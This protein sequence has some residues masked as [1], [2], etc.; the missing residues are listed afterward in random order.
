MELTK[1]LKIMLESTLVNGLRNLIWTNIS[2]ANIE[3][4]LLSITGQGNV[5]DLR[6]YVNSQSKAT[7][8]KLIEKSP[9][10]T[11]EMVEKAYEKYHY[12]QKPGFT[13]FWAKSANTGPIDLDLFG[14]ELKLYLE[15]IKYESDAK[16][17][18]LKFSNITKF[19]NV[20]EI[21]MT[22]LQRLIYI[23]EEG[24]FKSVYT[25][26]E[27]FAWI[28]I[29]KGFIAINNIPDKLLSTLKDYFSRKLNACIT[30]IKI[31][32]PVLQ[33]AFSDQNRKRITGY[34]PNPS[35]NQLEKIT[36]SDPKLN[37]KMGSLPVGYENY[38][39]VSTQ[40]MEEIDSNTSGLLGVNCDK[41]KLYISKNLTATQ[42]HEWSI[43][44]IN[45]ILNYFEN[46]TEISLS[47]ISDMNIFSSSDWDKIKPKA[48]PI[49][50]EIVYAIIKCKKE[51]IESYQV[52]F[53]SYQAF[54]IMPGYFTEKISFVCDSCDERVIPSCNTCGKS[55][56]TV[57][58]KE[59]AK[60]IC[61]FCGDSQI[62]NFTF[63]CERGHSNSFANINEVIDIIA[64]EDFAKHLFM[65]ISLYFPE[66]RFSPDEY[67]DIYHN[68]LTLHEEQRYAKLNPSDID[69]FVDIVNSSLSHD[70]PDL[71]RILSLLGEKCDTPTNE[72][73][74]TCCDY[75]CSNATQIGC[76]LKLFEDFEGYT[77]QPHHGQE[78]G[79]VSM[80]VGING[81]NYTFLGAA[82]SG[83]IKVTKSSKIGRE[84]VQQVLDAFNDSK[85]EV[86]GVIYPGLIDNQLKYLLYSEAKIHNKKFVVLDNEFMLK[87]LDNYLNKHSI[88]ID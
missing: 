30:N 26:K 78:F 32:K 56:F 54:T 24:E 46:Q 50:N 5:A 21:T 64:N 71:N 19:N 47:T 76:L 31:T 53:E 52:S 82:K 74:Q 48:I 38:N 1:E 80:L 17:K 7:L 20:I 42:F 66:I 65:T 9:E 13:L 72:K 39:V 59:P 79:D 83:F 35:N 49:L 14:K 45:S 8:I 10:I 51:N 63:V 84:I 12:G 6:K 3:T 25:M 58:R 61:P 88:P 4:R 15:D 27:A 77:T 73:C 85:A 16:Y 57:T 87:L 81:N 55:F 34:N 43:S 40:Y 29:E 44:R 68:N 69:S 41:G 2:N 28:G 62:G 75:P 11:L 23:D 22:Y 37:E 67:F 33:K 18:N 36:F 86:I 70:K 60:I